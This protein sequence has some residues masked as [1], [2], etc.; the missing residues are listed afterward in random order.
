MKKTFIVCQTVSA[1]LVCAGTALVTHAHTYQRASDYWLTCAA[2]ITQGFLAQEGLLAPEAAERLTKKLI[3]S[4]LVSD[5]Y[6]TCDRP[7]P[8]DAESLVLNLRLLRGGGGLASNPLRPYYAYGG[9]LFV[10]GILAIFAGGART[11]GSLR[12]D[13]S[14]RP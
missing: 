14:T 6:G 9:L 13:E 12:A 8:A 5:R 1:L 11:H 2:Q 3:L 10:A 4:G 7:I